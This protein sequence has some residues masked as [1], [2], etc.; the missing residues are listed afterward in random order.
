SLFSSKTATVVTSDGNILTGVKSSETVNLLATDAI[1]Q[2]GGTCGFN[3]SGTTSFSQ[4]PLTVG[5]FKVNESLCPKTLEAKYTQKALPKGSRYDS[6]AFAEEYTTLKAGTIAEQLETA[7]WQGDTGSANVNLNKFDGF[8]KIIDDAGSAVDANSAAY[9]GTPI[10]AG[11]GITS[12]N[13][14]TIVG[15][16][17]KGLPAVIKGKGDVRIWCGWDVFS[18]FV[19]KL[20]NDNLYHY[21]PAGTESQEENGEIQIPGT[22]YKLTAVHGLDGTNRLFALRSSNMFIGTDLQNE[23]ERWELFFAKEADEVRFVSEWKY[24]VQV[25][26]PNEIV[27]FTLTA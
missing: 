5:K 1:F 25:A 24:G 12:S 23:E 16:M 2:T 9:M 13:V 20:V 3:S 8:V 14:R 21:A 26:L 4:R 15:A 22:P 19:D 6:L 7:I 17:V 18:M 11:T 27:Q 10:A